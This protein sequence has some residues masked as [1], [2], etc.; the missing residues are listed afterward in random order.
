MQLQKD[1]KKPAWRSGFRIPRKPEHERRRDENQE[2]KKEDH[3]KGRK[4]PAEDHRQPGYRGKPSAAL[5]RIMNVEKSAK[6]LK[7]AIQ[8]TSNARLLKTCGLVI[9]PIRTTA[10]TRRYERR[11]KWRMRK[12]IEEEMRKEGEKKKKE[13]EGSK[14]KEEGEEERKKRE[15]EE[16]QL[17]DSDSD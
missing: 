16:E 8:T 9:Q 3:Q 13:G 11:L 17:L 15:E 14:E 2:K 5:S 6:R 1:E 12:E 4:R 7:Y 10:E